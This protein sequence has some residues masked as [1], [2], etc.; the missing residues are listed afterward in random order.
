MKIF[1]LLL[2]LLIFSTLPHAEDKISLTKQEIEFLKKHP[3]IVLGT[4]KDWKPYVIKSSDG[5]I[6]GYDV[7]VLRLINQ[8]SGANFVLQASHWKNMIEKAERREIDGLSTGSIDEDRKKYLNFSDIYITIKKM[9]ITSKENPK[10]INNIYDLENKVIAI[11]RSNSVDQKIARG[12]SKSKIIQFDTIEEVISSVV[13]DEADVMFGNG[14]VFYLANELGLPYLRRVGSLKEPLK[15]AFGIR[16]DWPEAI[17]I[18]NKSLHLIGEAKLLELKK[19]WFWDNKAL[20]VSK[21]NCTLDL[22]NREESY[23]QEKKIIKVCVDPNWMPFEQIKDGKHIGM[24]AE[25]IDILQSKIGVPF[26]LVPTKSWSQSLQYAKDRKCDILSLAMETKDRAKYLNFTTSYI[27]APLVLATKNDKSFVSSFS[28]LD[29]KRIGVSR[30]YA[31]AEF[32]RKRYAKVHFVEVDSV[33][34]GLE[35]VIEDRLFGFVGNLTTIGY[36]IQKDFPTELKIAARFNEKLYLSMGVRSDEIELLDILDKAISTIGKKRVEVIKNHWISIKYDQ[37]FNEKFFWYIIIPVI[38]LAL[39]SIFRQFI[40]RRYNK[41]LEE[42]VVK[43]V[44]ELREKDEL[45]F[46][47]YRMAAMGEMLSMIAHQ[48]RQPLGAISS[49]IMSIDVKLAS[50]K[51]DFEDRDSRNDFMDYLEK[52][53]NSINDYVHYLSETTDDFRN[54]FNPNRDKEETPLTKPI[55]NALNILQNFLE[56]HNIELIKDFQT[57]KHY[58]LYQNEI[59]Q[60]I[61]SMLKNS[62]EN[63]SANKT[64]NPLI[65]LKTYEEEN[66]YVIS[67]CDNGGGV[68]DDIKEK[69]FEPYFSTKKAKN[70]T[71]LGLYMSKIMVED[72]HG[73]VLSVENSDEGACFYIKFEKML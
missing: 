61:I 62:E 34:D 6:S 51:F 57:D 59:M 4:D 15:L 21:K 31:S 38:L 44:E 22:N 35:Q 11:H 53:H 48:W 23:L 13:T 55:V 2:I 49:A 28:E 39:F 68:P 29:G 69:I 24:S 10:K 9:I 17:S 12:L 14:A 47:K 64:E 66:Y 45:L 46:Q 33:S 40:L 26:S 65:T 25:Y 32:L 43:K 72:H 73:G 1:E 18:I 7:D 16:K 71:G 8:V 37:Q 19:K 36:Q 5:N 70:G 42:K 67:I 20:I 58:L 41:K 52:K 54:F 63:F 60:V 27:T 30:D 3:T 50:G 56:K